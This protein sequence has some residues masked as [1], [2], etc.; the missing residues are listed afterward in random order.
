MKLRDLRI[1]TRLTIGFALLIAMMIALSAFALSQMQGIDRRVAHED[2]V[3]SDRLERL[4][5]AREALAQTGIAA[6]NAYVFFKDDDARKELAIVD[7]QRALFLEALK[8]AAPHFSGSADFAKVQ[9][10]LDQMAEELKRPRKYRETGQMK[11][12]GEF[13]VNECSPL[14]R[15][16]VAD[17]DVVINQAEQEMAGAAAAVHDIIAQSRNLIV[18]AAALA[19]AFGV[20]LAL[21]LSRSITAPISSAVAFAKQVSVGDLTARVEVESSDETGQLLQALQDMNGNL[22]RIVTEVRGGTERIATASSQVAAGNQDLSART[23][24]QAASLEE[25]ASSMEE[26]TST[27]KQNADNARQANALAATASEVASKGGQVIDQVVLT[28]DAINASAA[29]IAD[30]ISVIDGIAFQTNI[31]ALNAA[32]EAARAGEQG[33]GFAVVA[34]EVRTLAQRSASAAKEIKALIGDSVDKVQTGSRLVS[35]AGKTM[36]EIVASVRSVTD[37]MA[38]ISAAS[39]EQTAGIEQINQVV[40]QMDQTTQQNAALVEQAASA[41]RSMQDQASRLAQSVAVFKLDETGA[42]ETEA[43]AAYVA[44]QA[45]ASVG[46]AAARVPKAIGRTRSP[47]LAGV[48]KLPL[49]VRHG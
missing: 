41:S 4:Y 22:A 34:T 28:M 2:K 27:V 14:R 44:P 17:M 18:L 39:A 38:E 25:T 30:I 48:G 43:Q 11:E 35:D 12:F 9:K 3:F 10:G 45:P 33:R 8:Q 7:Q 29:K 37:I 49:S 15:Q 16:I 1:R 24:Q 13:L 21:I 19:L 32:V 6:R 47:R 46:Q 31:L 20:G 5:Q 23:E 26:M 40:T 36:H 42:V